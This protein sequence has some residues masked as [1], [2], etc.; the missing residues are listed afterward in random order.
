MRRDGDHRLTRPDRHREHDIALVKKLHRRHLL[1]RVKRQ[2]APSG[3]LDK[4]V[5]ERV[6]TDQPRDGIS[7]I[8]RSPRHSSPPADAAPTARHT[9]TRDR[10]PP[11]SRPPSAVASQTL[12]RSTH[13][14]DGARRGEPAGSG[15]SFVTGA[16][17]ARD[18]RDAPDDP[19]DDSHAT[20]RGGQAQAPRPRAPGPERPREPHGARGATSPT[21][22]RQTP[23]G[24][25][26]AARQ[27]AITPARHHASAPSRHHAIT[28]SRHQ[29]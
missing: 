10:Q 25:H 15:R 7:E 4:R 29:P 1:L 26:S 17:R 3:P 27:R 23:P 6:S 21:R 16:D 13:G 28:P 5:I 8:H 9:H 18:T 11:F 20:A 19:A 2:T 14:Q 22:H 24:Q 12:G